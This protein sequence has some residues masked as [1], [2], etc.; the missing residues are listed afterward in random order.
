MWIVTHRDISENLT[1][2]TVAARINRRWY[3]HLA[4]WATDPVL[5][6]NVCQ[7]PYTF[8][9]RSWMTR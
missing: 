7:A 4:F 1:W 3:P 6:P 2:D 9:D 5:S 8:P